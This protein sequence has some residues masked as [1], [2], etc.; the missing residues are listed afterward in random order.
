MTDEE[1]IRQL[2]ARYA[3]AVTRRDADAWSATWTNDGVWDLGN[4]HAEG[5][6]EIVDLWRASMA[7]F[8]TVIQLV[9]QGTIDV[10]RDDAVGRWYLH[11]E[12][13]RAGI[14]VR[15]FGAYD[16]EYRRTADGWRFTRRA[17]RFCWR[18]DAVPATTEARRRRT[19]RGT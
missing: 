3:D 8:E 2:V 17:T 9:H 18:T 14:R 10:E 19:G 1:A 11:E 7:V 4:K 12:S 16:D 15:Y 5:R 6:D 13:M